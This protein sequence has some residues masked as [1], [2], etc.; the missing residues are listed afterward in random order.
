MNPPHILT[1]CSCSST[2]PL[3]APSPTRRLH[4]ASSLISPPHIHIETLIDPP[5]PQST[6]IVH[7]SEFKQANI[8]EF[9]GNISEF[10]GKSEFPNLREN[11][12][13][14]KENQHCILVV[15]NHVV[16]AMLCLQIWTTPSTRPLRLKVRGPDQTVDCAD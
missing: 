5:H 1:S 15:L 8:S 6:R 2:A 9:R 14:L 11:C 12:P 4:G 7:I 13:N 10:K 3:P 16:L